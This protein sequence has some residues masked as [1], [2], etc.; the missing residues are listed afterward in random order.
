V[1][2]AVSLVFAEVTHKSVLVPVTAQ[3]RRK[4]ASTWPHLTLRIIHVISPP[5][6]QPPRGLTWPFLSSTC[7]LH[8]NDSLHVDSPD[9]SHLP[10]VASTLCRLSPGLKKNSSEW[11]V[12]LKG[13]FDGV[14]W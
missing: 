13:P 10:R 11:D 9:P 14:V 6:W 4:T 12:T 5:R 1:P 7:H 8:Q 3:P 2:C